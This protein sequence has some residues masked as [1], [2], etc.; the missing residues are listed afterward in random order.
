MGT[1][2]ISVKFEFANTGDQTG[3]EVAQIYLGLPANIAVPPK[4]LVGWARVAL[5]SGER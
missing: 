5:D 4:K 3:M 2:L 1:Q